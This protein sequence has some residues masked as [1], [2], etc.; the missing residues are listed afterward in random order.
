YRNATAALA[1]CPQSAFVDEETYD[2]RTHRWTVKIWWGKA[3]EVVE[4]TVDDASGAVVDAW[5]GPQV[6]WGMLR[7]SPGAF[8]GKKINSPWVWGGFCLAFI[9]GLADWR[10][11][12]SLRNLDLVML[13][14]PTA[15]LWFF[16]HGNV[17]T[18]VP[19][20]YPALVW[21]VIRG[22][23]IGATGRGSRARQLWPTWLLLA[24]AVFR[25]G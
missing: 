10:R 12:L 4:G 25:A 1:R 17:F 20:F 15:S 19:L 24:A 16:N 13:L 21:V 2:A 22:G 23:W 8:G 7:G 11:P 6:A 9:I 14:S 3:G 5:A 18:A